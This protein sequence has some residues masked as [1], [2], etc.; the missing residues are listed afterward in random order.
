VNPEEPK[1]DVLFVAAALGPPG[2]ATLAEIRDLPPRSGLVSG[3]S[4]V[5]ARAEG[6][7]A[8]RIAGRLLD[9]A[10]KDPYPRPGS[11]DWA[12]LLEEAGVRARDARDARIP[13]TLVDLMAR[14]G[15]AI[16]ADFEEVAGSLPP[17]VA[18]AFPGA[19]LLEPGRIRLGQGVRIDPGVVLDAREGPIVLGDRTRVMANTV[20][21][22]P[23]CAGP[24]CLFKPL[25]RAM[26]G[27]C[28][29]PVC[30]VGG[31]IDATI[32]QGFSNKQHDGFLGHSYVGSWVNLG[33]ATDTSD[34]RNDYGLVRVT[35][36]GEEVDTGSRHVGSLVGDHSKTAIHTRL[37]T[38][39]VIGVSA[40]VF[41]SDFP[42]REIPSFTWGGG[43]EMREYRLEKAI[44]VASIV[45]ARRDVVF[46]PHGEALFG[47]LH[48][49]TA[50]RRAALFGAAKL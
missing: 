34:L 35:I 31:E 6:A 49:A 43:P 48:R 16:R 14:A 11:P 10:G 38:G 28:L 24:D 30:R 29:G 22:G 50:E 12:R 47:A 3:G 13:A 39:T 9:L 42:P 44:E 25:T 20:I 7:A 23:V 1:G 15:D 27:V 33:A 5:A 37:N 8:G 36:A 45:T 41:G 2:R 40:N 17:V 18:G 46:G 21:Q 26:D 4:L 19:H 32:L